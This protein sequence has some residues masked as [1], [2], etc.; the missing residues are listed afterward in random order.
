MTVNHGH[1]VESV[2]VF[3]S[4]GLCATAGK[5]LNL[6]LRVLSPLTATPP[7]LTP[8][9]HPRATPSRHAPYHRCVVVSGDNTLGTKLVKCLE[10]FIV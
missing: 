6:I 5:V 8:H 4:G 2:V 7:T 9:P 10:R 1:P 3:P